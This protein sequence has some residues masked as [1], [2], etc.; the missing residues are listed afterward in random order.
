MPIPEWLAG[1]AAG[2]FSAGGRIWSNDQA[3]Q[4]ANR[5]MAFQERMSSTAAQRAVEDYRRAGLNPA[6]AYDR[7]A[8][9]PGGAMSVPEDPITS[10]IS[11][12]QAARRL[13]AELELLGQQA[14]KTK[15]E[16]KEAEIR[17][18]VAQNTEEERTKTEIDELRG[19]REAIQ[20]NI[21]LVKAQKAMVDVQRMIANG[22]LPEAQARAELAKRMGGWA[23]L[24]KFIRPR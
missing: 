5:Q 18:R 13:Y 24:L 6:L 14:E 10:A 19:R 23:A 3:R 20:P 21:E 16:R 2:L 4:N 11:S 7:P 9:S 8:S 17:A 22:E 15:F 12:G 1:A